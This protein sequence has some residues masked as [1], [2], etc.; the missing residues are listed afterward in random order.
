[1]TMEDKAKAKIFRRRFF[2]LPILLIIGSL[3]IALGAGT[4]IVYGFL[5][6]S[7]SSVGSVNR[8]HQLWS[9]GDYRQ[10]HAWSDQILA[11]SPFNN[12]VLTMNGYSGFFLALSEI[13]SQ[14]AQ[15]YLDTSIHSLRI[16]RY[17]APKKVIPQLDYILGKAYYYKNVFS[18]YHYYADLAVKYLL[19]A[20]NLQYEASDLSEYLGLS[21]AALGMTRES[22]LCFTDALTTRDSDVLRLAIAEQYYHN[23]QYTAAKPYLFYLTGGGQNDDILLKSHALLGQMYQKENRPDD[24]LKEYALILKKDPNNADAL[25]EI[26]IIYEAQGDE[27]AAR[28]EWRRAFR[29]Q[30]NLSGA[31]QKL[32]GTR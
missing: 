1:M 24:A 20:E 21:Y 26:G 6:G 2:R 4:A 14:Q 17:E 30:V 23:G 11:D 9:N 10:V 18:A 19:S 25:Y 8:L 3:L 15:K 28:A 7:F 5:N 27:V 32:A 31:L 13:D 22:I 16:A 29:A 12:A